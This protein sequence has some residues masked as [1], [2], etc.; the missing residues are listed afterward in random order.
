MNPRRPSATVLC[1]ALL[2]CALCM[3][4]A[5]CGP[6][7]IG[8]GTADT[9]T[10]PV[11]ISTA[12]ALRLPMTGAT[13]IQRRLYYQNRPDIMEQVQDYRSREFRRRFNA[14]HGGPVN[15]EDPAYREVPQQR[16]PFK[17]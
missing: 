7:D 14:L 3:L 1:P 13:P 4:L 6:K 15:P 16:S 5:A 12:D 11:G 2:G 17:Q 8:T 9:D 10:E